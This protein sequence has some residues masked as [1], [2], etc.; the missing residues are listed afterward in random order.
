MTVAEFPS[1]KRD[2]INKI[3]RYLKSNK[4]LIDPFYIAKYFDIDV[5]FIPMMS[6]YAMTNYNPLSNSFSIYIADDVDRY[7]QKILCYHELGHILCEGKHPTY[8]FDGTID[9]E[10]EFTANLFM[11][12]FLPVFS[13]LDIK[14]TTDIKAINK[15]VMF[16]IHRSS[17]KNPEGIMPGQMT[18]FDTIDINDP[19]WL[20]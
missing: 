8:L 11:S 3:V 14:K 20:S 9:H 1:I 4:I 10:S 12:N 19:F 15:F 17:L 6:P 2:R 18:I 5:S 7:S 16:Q 13:R